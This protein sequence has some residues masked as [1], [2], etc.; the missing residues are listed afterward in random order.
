MLKGNPRL[1]TK[2]REVPT[3]KL[4]R[5]IGA[6]GGLVVDWRRIA[7]FLGVPLA[8]AVYA[9]ANNWAVIRVLGYP[10][11]IMFYLAHA[12]VPWW[13]TCLVT[14]A[15]KVSLRRWQ[16][17]QLVLLI[18]GTAIA[19]VLVLPYS[20]WL[21]TSVAE[22]FASP[23]AQPAIFGCGLV[24]LLDHDWEPGGHEAFDQL[25]I[26][27]AMRCRSQAGVLIHIVAHLPGAYVSIF[28]IGFQERRC[29]ILRRRVAVEIEVHGKICRSTVVKSLGNDLKAF[30]ACL[31]G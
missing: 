10:A 1:N 28:S 6:K 8:V 15:C 22:R 4:A 12:F 31:A 26:T 27:A 5:P 2:A 14:Q 29:F 19:C 9:A 21:T 13:T 17:P 23:D 30:D 11:T 20:N 24:T 3:Q 7:F 25:Q 18:M 16:P